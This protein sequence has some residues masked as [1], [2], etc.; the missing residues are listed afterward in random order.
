[1]VPEEQGTKGPPEKQQWWM[2]LTNNTRGGEPCAR[3]KAEA[4]EV[5]ALA[6]SLLE[7]VLQENQFFAFPFH[8]GAVE[9]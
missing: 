2:L 1:M 8:L 7:P 5:Q 9:N 3:L 6:S 4:R